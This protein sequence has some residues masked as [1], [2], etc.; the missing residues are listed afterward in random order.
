[1]MHGVNLKS[2]IQNPKLIHN[3]PVELDVA[4]IGGGPAGVAVALTLQK[5]GE[6]RIA[7]LEKSR[8]DEFRIGE[9]V[10]PNIRTVLGQLGVLDSFAQ[11]D[12][13][14]SL[15][16]CSAWGGSQLGFQDFFF[17]PGGNGWHLN[18]SRFD[19]ALANAAEKR[20]TILMRE[21]TVVGCNQIADGRWS[22]TLRRKNSLPFQV[23]T[24]FVVDA[25]GHRSV[26]ATRVGAKK[27][28]MDHLLGVAAV[29]TWDKDAPQDY[30]TLIEATEL[31]WWYAARLPN[32]RA[33]VTFMTD[34]QLLR[35][36]RLFR[37]E[38]WAAYLKKT[39]YIQKLTYQAASQ[40]RLL[41][42]PA[43]SQ[44]LDQMTGYGWLAVGD[45]AFSLDP[46]SSAGIYKALQSGIKAALAINHSFEGDRDALVVYESQMMHQFE[47]YLQD[48][49]KYYAQ[50][51]RWTKSPFWKSRRGQITLSPSKS[52]LFREFPQIA[53]A[54]KLNMYLPAKEL[55]LLCQL[56]SPG[57][58]AS[59]VVS[60]FMIQT[61]GKFSAYH[62]IEALQYLLEQEVIQSI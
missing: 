15:G 61:T 30:H 34:S 22:L 5:Q 35:K 42:Q 29:F 7:I 8:Q 28:R 43:F 17:Y 60:E 47:V 25:S 37:P 44:Y 51:T 57:K 20:G 48:R 39:Q 16:N 54:L 32:D 24:S 59:D 53:K 62:V 33:I 50:E 3:L 45:A 12:H 40:S 14:L 55:Q 41:I 31:G 19:T 10:P 38:T 1:F 58:K 11:D 21:T 4:I 46:L 18:R 2:K 26:F 52:L 36:Y 6:K 56:C 27:V 23:I 49:C 13:L 9:T